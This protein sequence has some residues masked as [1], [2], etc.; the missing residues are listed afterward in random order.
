M[1]DLIPGKGA[2]GMDHGGD[3]NCSIIRALVA[4]IGWLGWNLRWICGSSFDVF[5]VHLENKLMNRMEN[6]SCH[7]LRFVSLKVDDCCIKKLT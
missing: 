5:V 4:I 7:R 2:F 3:G 6:A 1:V